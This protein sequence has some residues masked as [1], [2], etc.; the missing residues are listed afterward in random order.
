MPLLTVALA[1]PDEDALKKRTRHRSQQHALSIAALTKV[2]C[3]RSLQHRLDKNALTNN[4]IDV[5]GATPN[6]LLY[7]CPW[8]TIFG[9]LLYQAALSVFDLK[10]LLAH[11]SVQLVDETRQVAHASQK[12]EQICLCATVGRS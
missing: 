10:I 7:R 2:T 12:N 8:Y 11:F 9:N 4:G 1:Q 6:Y 5:V 3:H